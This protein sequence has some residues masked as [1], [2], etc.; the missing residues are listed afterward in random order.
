MR[1]LLVVGVEGEMLAV[2]G[3]EGWRR[4]RGLVVGWFKTTAICFGDSREESSSEAS[5]SVPPRQRLAISGEAF[6]LFLK[7]LINSG[8]HSSEV[9]FCCWSK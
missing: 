9:F 8:L 3:A 5:D 1:V 7:M 2:M 6:C 4:G